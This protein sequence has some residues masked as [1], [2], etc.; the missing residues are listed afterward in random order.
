MRDELDN[1][2]PLS[3]YKESSVSRQTAD[4]KTEMQDTKWN[5]AANELDKIEQDF[6]KLTVDETHLKKVQE[7]LD[8]LKI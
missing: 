2:E 3:V 6:A 4:G 8:G 7:L 1:L 5:H